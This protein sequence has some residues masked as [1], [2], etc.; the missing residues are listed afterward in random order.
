MLSILLISLHSTILWIVISFCYIT[1]YKCLHMW[2][3]L[4]RSSF[5]GVNVHWSKKSEV[6][7]SQTYLNRYT[8]YIY[9]HTYTS[10][11]IGIVAICERLHTK[12]L[13]GLWKIV[14]TMSVVQLTFHVPPFIA[15]DFELFMLL[16]IKPRKV[17]TK[18]QRNRD[19]FISREL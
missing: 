10:P 11:G 8:L 16:T 2:Y 17:S 6:S 3:V 7:L 12:T 9:I 14:F 19:M 18:G 15:T 13:A 5:M 4:H 1:K